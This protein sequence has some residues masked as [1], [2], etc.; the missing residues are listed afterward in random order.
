[1]NVMANK[2]DSLMVEILRRLQADMAELKEGQRTANVHL[3]AI[4]NHMAGFHLTVSAHTDEL[5]AL[6]Q[7]IERIERR[8]ELSDAPNP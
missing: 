4:E 7:R 3:A 2:Q 6:R 5:S 8:L 1:M